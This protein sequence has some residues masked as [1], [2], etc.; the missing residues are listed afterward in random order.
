MLKKGLPIIFMSALLLGACMNTNDRALPRNDE[1]PMQDIRD[2]ERNWAPNVE[3]ERRGG[4]DLD[5]IDTND[6]R[7]EDTLNNDPLGN[8]NE[9]AVNEKGDRNLNN[10]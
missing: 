5:G 7:H 4:S 1:T 10:R 2:S 6:R 3:D 8:E 9:P